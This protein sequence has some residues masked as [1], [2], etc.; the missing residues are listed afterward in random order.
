[1]ADVPLPDTQPDPAASYERKELVQ[2]LRAAM[3]HMGER[4]KELMRLKLEGR[5]FPEIQ[6]ILKVRSIN[7]IYT[8]D[9]RCRK[10]L[11]ELMGIGQYGGEVRRQVG[12]HLNAIGPKL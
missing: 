1:M 11:L 2:R 3:A 10:H 12:H 4:C 7:T 9:H 6:A 5:S 8:W